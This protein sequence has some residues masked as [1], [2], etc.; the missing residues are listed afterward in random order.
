MPILYLMLPLSGRNSNCPSYKAS[1]VPGT[2]APGLDT[3]S[4][5]M[6]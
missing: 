2:A 5:K 4:M 1:V 3:A 6:A